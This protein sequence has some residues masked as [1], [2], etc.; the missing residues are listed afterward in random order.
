MLLMYLFPHYYYCYYRVTAGGSTVHAVNFF[1]QHIDGDDAVG[2][3]L[4][5]GNLL[6]GVITSVAIQRNVSVLVREE[7]ERPGRL[8]GGGGGEKERGRERER[9]EEQMRENDKEEE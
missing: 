9:K 1:Y 2:L 6:S 7:R 8:G 3:N 5:L 4:T